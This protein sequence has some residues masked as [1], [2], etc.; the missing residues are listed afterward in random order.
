MLEN[1]VQCFSTF[2]LKGNLPKNL[3]VAQE[4]LCDNPKCL[5]YL[6]NHKPWWC[7]I[8]RRIQGGAKGTIL[9]HFN[10]G[11]RHQHGINL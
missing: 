11:H 4:Y 1:L 3:R 7:S 8:H 5:F 2:L 6:F 10:V 9:A